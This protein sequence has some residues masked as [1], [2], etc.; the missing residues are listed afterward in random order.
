MVGIV[1]KF[2]INGEE[3]HLFDVYESAQ[4]S[5]TNTSGRAFLVEKYFLTELSHYVDIV[6]MLLINEICLK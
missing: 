6:N 1:H 5:F 4:M 2:R 3:K